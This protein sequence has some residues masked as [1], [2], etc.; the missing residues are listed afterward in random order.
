MTSGNI[1]PWHDVVKLRDDVK[2][3]E[4]TLAMFAADLYDV[5][6]GTAK[7]VYSDPKEFFTL[8]FPA[9]GIRALARDVAYRLSGKSD[10]AVRQLSLTYGGGKTYAEISEYHLH[11][12]PANLP[13]VPAVAEFRAEMGGL[14][15]PKA[16]IVVL[17]FDKLDVEKGMEMVDPTG[18]K[19]WLKQPWSVLAWQIAGEAG[20]KL[21][22]ADGKAEERESAP[23][24]NLMR[25]LL[26]L[27]VKEGGALLLLLDEVLMYAHEKVRKERGWLETLKNFFQYMTQAA[28]KTD[29]VVWSHLC[30]PP[31]WRRTIR[32]GAKSNRNCRRYSSARASSKSSRSQKRKRRKC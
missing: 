11:N 24:E 30:S 9:S 8:T 1:K 32:P 7:S 13:D 2:S 27:G 15:I 26:E 6:M 16:R 22:H 31:M 5:K 28:T 23:A 3:G 21:L 14:A 12:D 18:K 29:V 19:R 17:P 10:K 4:L 25:L 20:L